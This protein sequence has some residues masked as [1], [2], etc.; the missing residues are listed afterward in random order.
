MRTKENREKLR[1]LSKREILNLSSSLKDLE[2]FSPAS[3]H[4][5][6]RILNYKDLPIKHKLNE[7]E[8]NYF[9][10]FMYAGLTAWRMNRGKNRLINFRKFRENIIKQKNNLKKLEKKTIINFSDEDIQMLKKIFMKLQLTETRKKEEYVPTKS[11]IVSNSK[12][13]HFILPDLIP[14]IDNAFTGKIY[15]LTGNRNRQFKV[16]IKTMR[17]YQEIMNKYEIN[18]ST[19]KCSEE[20]SWCTLGKVMDNVL[21]KLIEEPK[22]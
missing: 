10:D 2:D 21:I 11:V 8:D 7:A 20:N 9:F 1:R 14:P 22:N 17:L 12:T 6:N 3:D 15:S 18:K 19:L 13:L 5:Y 4:F 16:F